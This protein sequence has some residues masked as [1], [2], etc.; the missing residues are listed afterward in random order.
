MWWLWFAGPLAAGLISTSGGSALAALKPHATASL[1]VAPATG[2]TT[3]S[4]ACQTAAYTDINAAML[5]AYVCNRAEDRTGLL[6]FAAE[7]DTG[8][9]QVVAPDLLHELGIVTAF[10]I[11][12]A[13]PR[14]LGPLL[15]GSHRSGR[16]PGGGTASRVLRGGLSRPDQHDPLA[17]QQEGVRAEREHSL[18]AAGVLQRDSVL[19][20][21]DHG[22]AELGG[23]VFDHQ[24][25]FSRAPRKRALAGTPA[26][27]REYI[28]TVLPAPHRA[29]LADPGKIPHQAREW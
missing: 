10:D 3:L 18:P 24:P 17:F 7:V 23:G 21:P 26:S 13:R 27:R 2:R 6:S 16:R 9:A 11:D 15:R 19:L 5:A 4:A 28:G 22:P 20:A 29:L 14:D 8:I 12:P 1:W 25:V